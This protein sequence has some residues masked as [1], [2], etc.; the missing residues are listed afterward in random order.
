MKFIVYA[1][2]RDEEIITE[3]EYKKIESALSDVNEKGYGIV[4]PKPEE[5]QF[6]EP[7]LVKHTNGRSLGDHLRIL[8]IKLRNGHYH[9]F[10]L[11]K[12]ILANIRQGCMT[13]HPGCTCCRIN[14]KNTLTRI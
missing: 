10:K 8:C 5:M 12:L 6:E 9:G 3:K 1:N 13:S 14:G 11:Y 4:M 7:S 2:W